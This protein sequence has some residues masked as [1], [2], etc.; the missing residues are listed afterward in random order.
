M[1]KRSRDAMMTL[2]QLMDYAS[3]INGIDKGSTSPPI[4]MD[5]NSFKHDDADDDIVPEHNVDI[6]PPGQDLSKTSMND[7]L[8]LA[9]ASIRAGRFTTFEDIKKFFR[10]FGLEYKNPLFRELLSDRY[11]EN[12]IDDEES[13]S[14]RYPWRQFMEATNLYL[15]AVMAT[16]ETA[17]ED[18]EDSMLQTMISLRHENIRLTAQERK[19]ALD[20]T[21]SLQGAIHA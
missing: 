18:L 16:F 2:S 21:K 10:E 14:E 8:E 13:L 20:A 7:E 1:L 4:D 17:S 15:T 6:K 9:L 5:I 3:V 19:A 11:E 12:A